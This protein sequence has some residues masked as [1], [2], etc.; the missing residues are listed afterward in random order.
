MI[1]PQV[2]LNVLSGSG[3]TT[4]TIGLGTQIGYLFQGPAVNSFFLAGTFA[5][6]STSSGG[7][8]AEDFAVGG[9]LG[10]RIPIGNSFGIRFEG[11]YRRWFDNE[12]NE[13]SFGM[14]LGGVIRSS[15]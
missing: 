8:S 13:F 4:T 11:G 1:E 7:N 15:P 12:L 14:S 2:A 5:F 10:Y 3:M 9:K 6:Q